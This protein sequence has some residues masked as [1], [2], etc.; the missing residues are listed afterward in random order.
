[1][2]VNGLLDCHTHCMFSPDGNDDPVE[3]VNKAVDLGLKAL[4]VTDHCECNTWFEPE[5]YGI[6]SKSAD[7]DDILMYNCKE[8]HN[9][10][11]EKMQELKQRHYDDG[12]EFIHGVELGQP[13]QAPEIA[14]EI[15][16]D[17]SI[18]YIIGSLHNNSGEKDFYFLSF[19]RLSMNDIYSLLDDYY[20][21]VLEMCQQAEFDI[22][23]H[24]TYPY[25]YICGKYGIQ[26]DN[27]RY[28]D[29]SAEIFRTLIAKGK[30]IEINTSS[31]FT[32]LAS[33]MPGE[34]LVRLYRDLGGEILSLGS[35]AHCAENVGQGID[36]G[37]QLAK[38]CGF[39][40][41]AYFK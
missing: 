32:H 13:L 30:G 33:T 9:K 11:L 35:D 22:L 29:I 8:Y 18:D 31:L 6:D 16:S 39:K 20:A 10:S 14:R 23:G 28:K 15:T 34:E 27:S 2:N 26:I 21:Q 40:Y 36:I 38:S 24:L 4:A 5:Y 25:R 12:F 19:D 1:M 3:L 41:A 7:E 37:A 17:K